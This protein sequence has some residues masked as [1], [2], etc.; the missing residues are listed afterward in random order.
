MQGVKPSRR[1][2]RLGKKYSL[3]PEFA[4]VVVKEAD[5]ILGGVPGALLTLKDG[6]AVAN[7]GVDRKNAPDNA[8]ILWPANPLASAQKLQGALKRK[9]GVAMG[10]TIIDSRVTPLRLGTIGLALASAGFSPVMDL[11]GKSDLYGRK[12]RITFQALG[13]GIAAAA[14]VLMGEGGER[15]PFVLIRGA[16]VEFER[17]HSRQEKMR[18]NDCLYMSQISTGSRRSGP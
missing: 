6:Q 10:V 7:A 18:L 4:E 5:R 2:F 15:I 12:V 13:D 9:Y 11:R 1:A 8:A 17:E 16:P 14:H 3:P